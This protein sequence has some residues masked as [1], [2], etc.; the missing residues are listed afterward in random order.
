MVSDILGQWKSNLWNVPPLTAFR[1]RSRR[2]LFCFIVYVGE[3]DFLMLLVSMPGEPQAMSSA[4]IGA[5]IVTCIVG[6]WP[7]WDIYF[8]H[9]CKPLWKTIFDVL[10][11]K[12]FGKCRN[13]V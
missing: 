11:V 2:I 3:L 6:T 1:I 13:R 12:G 5:G 8:S 9:R 4:W 10:D 7:L